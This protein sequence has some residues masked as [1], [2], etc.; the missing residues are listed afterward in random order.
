MQVASK[1][2]M[3]VLEFITERGLNDYLGQHAVWCFTNNHEVNSVYDPARP[4]TSKEFAS[5]VAR[6]KGVPAPKFYTVYRTINRD[7]FPAFL[8]ERQKVVLDLKWTEEPR[9]ITAS[10]YKEDGSIYR[11]VAGTEHITPEGHRIHVE[12]RLKDVLPGN[13]LV[14]VRDD[15]NNVYASQEVTID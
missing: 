11:R 10:I 14:K 3:Q 9:N 4:E 12:F 2:L 5:L 7:G 6:L 1:E 15:E 13:Y 8:P